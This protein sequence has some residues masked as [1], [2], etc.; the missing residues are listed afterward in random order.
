MT[1][2]VACNV[3]LETL[4]NFVPDQADTEGSAGDH[5]APTQETSGVFKCGADCDLGP[6]GNSPDLEWLTQLDGS[7]MEVN[8]DEVFF[9]QHL[10]LV[11][12]GQHPR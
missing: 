12:F 3:V 7:M 11:G 10:W 2:H 1:A 4:M 5:T 6:L 9:D 8:V